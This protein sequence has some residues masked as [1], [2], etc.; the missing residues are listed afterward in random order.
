MLYR[1]TREPRRVHKR[2]VLFGQKGAEQRL[3]RVNRSRASGP[4]SLSGPLRAFVSPPLDGPG[5]VLTAAPVPHPPPPRPGCRYLPFSSPYRNRSR[6]IFTAISTSSSTRISFSPL[7]RPRPRPR[8]AAGPAAAGF[9]EPPEL[10]PACRGKTLL[11]RDMAPSPEA[12]GG[13]TAGGGAGGRGGGHG[14][15]ASAGGAGTAG[16][17]TADGR[18]RAGG[19][20]GP[21]RAGPGRR[22]VVT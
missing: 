17:A 5:Q 8:P 1:H 9:P 13:T 10:P 4:T 7:P 12:G 15:G 2:V 18:C 21:D 19:G 14:D 3:L 16:E 20:A 6:A 11:G 22:S